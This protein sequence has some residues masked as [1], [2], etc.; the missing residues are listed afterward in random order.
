MM[1]G[2]YSSIASHA[3]VGCTQA[4]MKE[5]KSRKDIKRERERDRARK[6]TGPLFS[7]L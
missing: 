4:E 6:G 2:Q 3:N 1:G 7:V 5:R